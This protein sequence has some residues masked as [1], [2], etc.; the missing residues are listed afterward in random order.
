MASF[1]FEIFALLFL[2]IFR[3]FL[4]AS[5]L[6]L[7]TVN[8]IRVMQK[9]DEGM[10]RAKMVFKLI[11][12]SSKF[13]SA[14]LFLALLS[15]TAAAAIA[16]VLVGR[17][18]PYGAAIATGGVTLILFIYAEMIPKTY[19]INNSE[20]VA[21]LVV[22]PV[23]WLT[24]VIYPLTYIFI[25]IANITTKALGGRI[26]KEGPFLSE[27]EIKAIVT[28][29]EEE[30]VIEEEEKEM[31]YS[32]FE[33][34]DTV[35]REVMIPR[36]DMHA[37]AALTPLKEV[38]D[39]IIK[40]GHSRIPV[41]QKNIDNIIGIIYAK[42]LLIYLNKPHDSHQSA[43]A[44]VTELMRQAYF[45]PESKHVSELLKEMQKKKSH[46]AIVLDEYGGTAGL[47]TI[48]DILEE[49]VGE[50]FDEYDLEEAMIE[51]LGDNRYRLDARAYLD[52]VGEL[53]S[54]KSP[55]DVGDTIGGLVYNLVGHTPTNGEEVNFQ[56]LDFTVEKVVGRR[57]LKIIVAKKE[58]PDEEEAT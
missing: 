46:M 14:L 30:G 50:I 10:G 35:V 48:E 12:E 32:I 21:Y 1:W 29:G 13:L 31:I 8:R 15:D 44:K 25:K 18:L 57:I 56:N 34:S 17:Y 33:F 22:R 49:I 3:T 45:V 9:A 42:D 51:P 43:D 58:E 19:A 53:L 37:V 27:E 55:D 11:G 38:M 36:V 24:R 2:L 4:S 23:S 26:K 54:T 16:T 40:V 20:K 47:I 6:S 28:V 41:Y 5:E 7:T 39:L 52:E